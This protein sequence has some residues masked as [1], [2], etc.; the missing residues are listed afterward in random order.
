[1]FQLVISINPIENLYLLRRGFRVDILYIGIGC[2]RV[3][4]IYENIF[5]TIDT[6]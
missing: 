6:I 2:L 5:M 4:S 1:M 3:W